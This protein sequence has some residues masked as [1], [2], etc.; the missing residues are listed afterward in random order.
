MPALATDLNRMNTSAISSVLIVDDDEDDV[1]LARRALRKGGVEAAVQTCANG[2][3]ALA[4]VTA[5]EKWPDLILLDVN[6]PKMNGYQF[7]EATAEDRSARDVFVA[8]LT[9]SS[10]GPDRVRSKE[11]GAGL[12]IEK[13]LTRGAVAEL[14]DLVGSR[15]GVSE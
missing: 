14:L 1:F 7:L 6:M 10:S 5:A 12:H 13:P 9:S 2:E 3:E 8:M 4:Y 11:L 15:E